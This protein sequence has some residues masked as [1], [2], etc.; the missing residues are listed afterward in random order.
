MAVYRIVP[1]LY[2][3]AVITSKAFGCFVGFVFGIRGVTVPFF[4]FLFWLY[5]IFFRASTD[6]KQG[7]TLTCCK[8]KTIMPTLL[9]RQELLHT[10]YISC[11]C[12][13][14]ADPTELNSNFSTLKCP[15]CKPGNVICLDPLGMV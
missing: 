6:I 7:D 12:E 8:V 15:K 4:V 5:R 2:Y 14:C 9:R 13:R 11:C 10:S 1:R 3:R